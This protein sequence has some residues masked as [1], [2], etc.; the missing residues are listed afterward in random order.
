MFDFLKKMGLPA[1]VA[2]V[3]A[4]LIA[5]IPMIFKIDERYAKTEEVISGNQQAADRINELS[6]EVG[7]LAG[8]TQVLVAVLSAKTDHIIADEEPKKP[9]RRKLVTTL[10]TPVIN[11]AP[12]N[13]LEA[14]EKLNSVS[15][16]LK[17]TQQNLLS[18]QAQ[19]QPM[20]ASAKK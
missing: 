20:A 3:V 16:S 15:N 8:T 5:V 11:T 17:V 2:G 4:A 18:I 10:T 9:H 1:M 7:R 14:I 19:N 6:I 13:S 12:K